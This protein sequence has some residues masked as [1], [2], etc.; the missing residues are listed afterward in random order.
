MINSIQ[1]RSGPDPQFWGLAASPPRNLPN[2]HQIPSP[3]SNASWQFRN[4]DL[5]LELG[6]VSGSRWALDRQLGDGGSSRVGGSASVSFQKRRGFNMVSTWMEKRVWMGMEKL[7]MYTSPI[8][9][10]VSTKPQDPGIY[11]FPD[12]TGWH[13]HH[14]VEN[15]TVPEM[16]LEWF[17]P[18]CLGVA[19]DTG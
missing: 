17:R 13:L 1:L 12:P 3:L 7:T 4:Q 5:A 10:Q 14:S 15:I 2:S 8:G 11:T 9:I 6:N 16:V 19:G 18:S